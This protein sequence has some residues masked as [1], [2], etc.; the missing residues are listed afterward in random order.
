MSSMRS[1]MVFRDDL[2]HVAATVAG[3]EGELL[4]QVWVPMHIGDRHVLTTCNQHSWLD[5][6]LA[7]SRVTGRSA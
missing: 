1:D 3:A 2:D 4:V 5:R 7:V 6:P